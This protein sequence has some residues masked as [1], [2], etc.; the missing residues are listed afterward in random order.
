ML[1]SYAFANFQSFLE[2]TEVSLRLNDKAA[3]SGW[4]VVSAGGQRLSTALAVVGANGAGKTVVLKPLAFA[5]W[6]IAHSFDARPEA[7]IP[8]SPHFSAP[9]APTQIEVEAEDAEGVLWRYVLHATPAK[10]VHEAL[11]RKLDRFSYVFVRDLDASGDGY[12]I[13]QKA[14]GM[15]AAEAAKVRPNASLISTARQYGVQTAQHITHFV[16]AHNVSFQGRAVFERQQLELA[17]EMFAGKNEMRE[18]MVRLLRSWDLGLSGVELRRRAQWSDGR[19]ANAWFAFGQHRTHDGNTHE[20]PLEDESSGTQ[21]AFVLLWRLLTVLG[22]GGLALIDELDADLHPH[23]VEPILD[24]FADPASNP[25][26]AQVIF[27]GHTPQ[28]LALLQKAQVLFVEKA[29][30]QSTAYRGDTIVG[31]RSD[32]NLYGKYMAGALGAVP[33]L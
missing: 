32:D 6:F 28:V 13:K 33:Q 29:D 20:L 30:C 18:Q 15:P 31:L 23:M 22:G 14:F 1:H 17:A 19:T 16:M 7:P 27:T 3:V 11:Y 10:V 8:L 4:Q 9:E 26:H 12:A 21:S 5:A 2:R 25:H 24:L